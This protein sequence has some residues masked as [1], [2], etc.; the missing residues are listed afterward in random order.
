MSYA[1]LAEV[2]ELAHHGYTHDRSEHIGSTFT[3]GTRVIWQTSYGWRTADLVGDYYSDHINFITLQGAIQ[4]P[5]VTTE[6]K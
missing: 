6:T 1:T 4:R 2:K 3:N 5:P